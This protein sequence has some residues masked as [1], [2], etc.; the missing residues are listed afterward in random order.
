MGENMFPIII[1]LSSTRNVTVSGEH[2]IF[3]RIVSV[4]AVS[5]PF[6]GNLDHA[7]GS[8]L[9][10]DTAETV[11]GF[12]HEQVTLTL[13]LALTLDRT[14]NLDRGRI[15]RPL[16][17][18]SQLQTHNVTSIRS[19]HFSNLSFFR[20]HYS[21]VWYR[22]CPEKKIVKYLPVQLP[23]IRGSLGKSRRYDRPVRLGR[24]RQPGSRSIGKD[25]HNPFSLSII[26]PRFYHMVS[27]FVQKR[28]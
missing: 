21:T 14:L 22:H 4:I 6:A 7:I 13:N 28:K 11:N 12:D 10:I 1:R 16:I 15:L 9:E 25:I 2:I 17:G 23:S 3:P 8:L 26:M 19:N 27:A 5:N 18:A 20:F 24:V